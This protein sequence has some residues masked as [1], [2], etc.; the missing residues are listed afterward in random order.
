MLIEGSDH[1]IG[2]RSPQKSD[3]GSNTRVSGNQ[4]FGD[5]QFL[6]QPA[7]VEGRAASKRDQGSVINILPALNRM[8][9]G[10]AGHVLANRLRDPERGI[11]RRHV[12]RVPD[13]F[14][15]GRHRGLPIQLQFAAGEIVGV[16]C[17]QQQ[18]RI[19]YRRFG[20]TLAITGRSG[21][22]PRALGPDTD[23]AEL[24][25]PG[26]R[27]AAGADLHHLDYGNSKRDSAVLAKPIDPSNLEPAAGLGTA[28]I[29]ETNFR[30]GAAHVE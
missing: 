4:N 2:H 7:G 16:D 19:R 22:R 13:G 14:F 5:T 9:P 25:H 28:I 12:H 27:P 24:V 15:D 18:I 8:Y 10:G 3:G 23:A 26:N 30:R 21:T 29:D 20:C 1:L 11:G 6:R 17:P